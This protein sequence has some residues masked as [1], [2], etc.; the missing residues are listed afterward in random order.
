M[1]F[2]NSI[3][4][5][6]SEALKI[7]NQIEDSSNEKPRFA[8]FSA[9]QLDQARNAGFISDLIDVNPTYDS[10]PQPGSNDP[11]HFPG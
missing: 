1:T 6:Y 4:L 9:V 8:A 5:L 10:N 11:D 3:K 2:K 7:V